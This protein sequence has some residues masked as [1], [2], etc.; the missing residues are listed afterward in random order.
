MQVT[1]SVLGQGMVCVVVRNLKS[2][3][4]SKR[5]QGEKNSNIVNIAPKC[6]FLLVCVGKAKKDEKLIKRRRTGLCRRN[7]IPLVVILNH[8]V[9]AIGSKSTAHAWP[10]HP[11]GFLC[12]S[13]PGACY[14]GL[15]SLPIFFC[16]VYS[17]YWILIVGRRTALN[18]T[19]PSIF[20]ML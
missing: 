4:V 7:R 3:S 18:E 9:R 10:P 5:R 11:Q 16:A 2:H 15:S 1:W 20:L 8:Q 13:S 17:A 19:A 6:C 12:R 14:W